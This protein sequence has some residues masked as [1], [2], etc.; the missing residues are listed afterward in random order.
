MNTP[1]V[2]TSATTSSARRLT[3][4]AGFTFAEIMF[5]VV[6]LGVGFIMIAAIFPVAIRQT[7]TTMEETQAAVSGRAALAYL[8][9]MA[10]NA[11]F[12]PTVAKPKQGDP[13]PVPPIK[14]LPDGAKFGGLTGDFFGRGNAINTANPRLAW[15]AL[16]R[17]GYEIDGEKSPFAQVFMI[18]VQVR[19]RT[20]YYGQPG[21][22][23]RDIDPVGAGG[24]SNLDP[25]P[26]QVTVAFD[27]A[28]QGGRLTFGTGGQ[29]AAPGAFVVIADVP[30]PSD[31]VQAAAIG[32][33]Y[34]LSALDGT[35]GTT[36]TLAPGSDMIPTT[37]G[38]KSIDVDLS[39]AT[40]YIVGRG[41]TDPDNNPNTVGA[42][43]QDTG[44]YVGFVQIPF[45]N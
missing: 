28:L 17:R 12:P 44:A 10:S 25:H 45:G 14:S 29:F 41:V 13:I 21:R 20:Q 30:N 9:S 31:P 36:W 22:T 2:T 27:T 16:Y 37:D 34:Q 43:A 39:G 5:A 42:G 35:G 8:Q 4:R 3:A 6:I 19:G 33:V 23:W 40:A 18:P 11:A 26:V 32:R 1:V 15:V 7:Q 24:Y 38:L